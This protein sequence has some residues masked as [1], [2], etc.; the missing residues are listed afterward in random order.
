MFG[1]GLVYGLIIFG[2]KN[3][4]NWWEYMKRPHDI[5]DSATADSSMDAAYNCGSK[6]GLVN[7]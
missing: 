5:H 4:T 3:W 1:K 2:N 7:S 6:R